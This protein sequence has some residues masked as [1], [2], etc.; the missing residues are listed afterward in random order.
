MKNYQAQSPQ[1]LVL[2]KSLQKFRKTCTSRTERQTT[3]KNDLSPTYSGSGNKENKRKKLAGRNA[4]FCVVGSLGKT[5]T[6][7]AVSRQTY[8]PSQT[9]STQ[10]QYQTNVLFCK[11]LLTCRSIKTMTHIL[12]T[13]II[14][15]FRTLTYSCYPHRV[16]LAGQ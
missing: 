16:D 12:T 10:S 14:T 4:N 7:K 11:V 2:T 15:N 1:N 3:V 6:N 9:P 8:I 13:D 5:Q